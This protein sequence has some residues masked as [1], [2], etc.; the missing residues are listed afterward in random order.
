MLSAEQTKAVREQLGKVLNRDVSQIVPE[1]RLF[2]DLGGTVEDLKSLR[3]AIESALDVQIEPITDAINLRTASDKSGLLTKESL[4]QI[5]AYLGK[6]P[7][8]P[9]NP[10][11]FPDLFTVGM[12]E[13]TVEKAASHPPVEAE[14]LPLILAP[15]LAE[16]IHQ[17]VAKVYKIPVESVHA[18]LDL[19][20][21][22]KKGDF[23]FAMA[24]SQSGRKLVIDCDAEMTALNSWLTSWSN[25]TATALT[26]QNLR[27]F[28]PDI[29]L[30]TDDGIDRTSTVGFIER[31]FAAAIERRENRSA[32]GSNR[33]ITESL[34]FYFAKWN[35]ADQQWWAKLPA[36]L[37]TERYRLYLTGMMR[38][39]FV[40]A[41]SL[42]GSIHEILEI[43]EKYA[44]TGQ[45]AA[46]LEKKFRAVNSWKLGR[47][48][49][50]GGL[51]CVLKPDC[52][53]EDGGGVLFRLE[54]AFRWSQSE[55]ISAARNWLTSLTSPLK[56]STDLK[57]EWCTAEVVDVARQMHEN[58]SF[59][60]FPKLGTLLTQAG[61]T[62]ETILQHCRGPEKWHLR[63]DWLLNAILAAVPADAKPTRG[64]ASAAGKPKKT[65][66]PT[67]TSREKKRFKELLATDHGSLP[68]ASA[69]S[70]VWQSSHAANQE[71]Y[72]QNCELSADVLTTL[73]GMY[74]AR[75]VVLPD[76]AIARRVELQSASEL[77]T[78]LTLNARMSL[79]IWQS[80]PH[81][82]QL[83]EILRDVFA[84]GDEPSLQWAIREFPYRLVMVTDAGCWS[85]LALRAIGLRDED[86]MQA[87][88]AMW[89]HPVG[90]TRVPLLEKGLNAILQRDPT[91]IVSTLVEMLEQQRQTAE[92]EGFGAVSLT[93]HACYRAAFWLNPDLVAGFD[94]AQAAP[95]DTEFHAACLTNNDPLAEF[96]F[97]NTPAPL[98]ELLLTQ[99]IPDWLRALQQDNQKSN[100]AH[101]IVLTDVGQSVDAVRNALSVLDWTPEEFIYRTAKLPRTLYSHFNLHSANLF[102]DSL[103]KAGATVEVVQE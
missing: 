10:V 80:K 14:R 69:W 76:V 75:I 56:D 95:W 70:T 82:H 101:A 84:V 60:E 35:S 87:L 47:N 58:R 22:D 51:L 1:A 43:A 48:P 53:A 57:P 90:S 55:V 52:T 89:P 2:A 36:Q 59:V 7:T 23:L 79:L 21:L 78:A 93:I 96:D 44:E 62:L 64:K 3:L 12:I 38:A 19:A 24:I 33:G 29:D 37:G 32:G 6:W 18:N 103:Q 45:S 61:C 13:A 42:D 100:E 46:L 50:W 5:A 20:P 88:H 67:M 74:P 16:R 54:H 98:K 68:V 34:G 92:R 97:S 102:C 17:I 65:K 99:Q 86:Q 72:K 73:G 25:G 4:Q 71:R 31:V 27:R 91:A 41:G 77:R 11:S 15:D 83:L 66:F 81:F 8:F 39:A 28:V 63:G 94:V 26:L 30:S 49:L 9:T 40:E 85:Y